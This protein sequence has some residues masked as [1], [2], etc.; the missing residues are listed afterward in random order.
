MITEKRKIGD[1]GENIAC[2][3]LVKHGMS[4]VEKNYLKPWG[5]IDIV[6]K[7]GDIVHFIEVKTVTSTKGSNVI[8]ETSEEYR[9][10]DNIH[11]QKL[12]RLGRTIQ[13]Y[14]LERNVDE[15]NWQ[16]DVITV[17]LSDN[18]LRVKVEYI[19]NIVL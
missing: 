2:K 1:L 19:E 8:R 10:E 16:F 13:T 7:A 3:F 12:K 5:E 18:L 9:A 4:I 11:P 14:M 17:K 6:A 15:E